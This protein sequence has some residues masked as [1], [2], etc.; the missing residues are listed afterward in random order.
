MNMMQATANDPARRDE[1]LRFKA[2]YNAIYHAAHVILDSE[3]LDLQIYAGARHILGRPVARAD[4]VRAKRV[5]HQWLKND[6]PAAGRAA[7]HAAHILGES[8]MN[9][10]DFQLIGV[11]HYPWCLYL[12]NITCWAFH[13]AQPTS[14]E[15]PDNCDH[16]AAM[17]E[18]DDDI[19]WDAKAEMNAL[20][21]SMTTSRPEDLAGLAGKR[22]V[23]GLTAVISQALAKVRWAVVH[24]ANSVLRGLVPWRLI[25][26]FEAP[27][28]IGEM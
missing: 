17:E 6:A 2:A 1:V 12:A 22:R 8:I 23:D 13:H 20:I 14:K 24:D 3:F 15:L 27:G 21:S 16:A 9:L 26:Q 7:W 11:F 5:V 19:I 25:N 28:R 10:E 18:D 4:Y